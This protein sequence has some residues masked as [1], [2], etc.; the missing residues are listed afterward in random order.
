M[1]A[2]QTRAPDE[3]NTKDINYRNR[4]RRKQ[5]QTKQ[6]DNKSKNGKNNTT[7]KI[8][9]TYADSEPRRHGQRIFI[10]RQEASEK[11]G[12]KTTKLRKPVENNGT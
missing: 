12:E 4:N 11:K 7:N 6:N 1:Q 5:M 3:K 2:H 10:D 8:R 9:H